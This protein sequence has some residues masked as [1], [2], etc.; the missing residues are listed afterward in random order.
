MAIKNEDQILAILTRYLEDD[1][2]LEEQKFVKDWIS[3]ST[4]NKNYF[5]E[6]KSIWKAS[7]DIAD[8]DKIDVEEEWGSFKQTISV[9]ENSAKKKVS[10]TVFYRIAAS[11]A[12][13]I[14]LG[15]YFLN[16]YSANV[17]LVAEA[18]KENRFEL[19]DASVVWLKEGSQLTYDK[20][21]EG[22][23]RKTQLNGEAFF[24][25]TKNPDK[26]FIV[27]TNNTETKVLGT[28]F[29]L[30]TNTETKETEIVLVTGKVQFTAGGNQEILRPGDKVTAKA[31]GT[32]AKKTNDNPNFISWKS[33][34]LKFEDTL[35]SEVVEDIEQFYNVKLVIEN[36]QLRHCKLTSVFENESL[37]DVLE[38]L[39]VLF[40]ITHQKDEANRIIIKGGDCNS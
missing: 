3:E 34:V 33:K 35:L 31:N 18:G 20:G 7:E 38:T 17:T 12:I 11:V 37:E 2:E 1:V 4:A 16:Y 23:T 13:I 22:E 19:P 21:F 29:N 10:N 14:G 27:L 25:V 26:P 30:K 28:S 39:T 36:P 40:D 32:L 9:Q 6:V 5:E 24:E 8:F 15:F